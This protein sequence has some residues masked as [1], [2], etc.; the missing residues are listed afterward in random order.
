MLAVQM[1]GHL[2]PHSGA[3]SGVHSTEHSLAVPR[4]AS[5][6]ELSNILNQERQRVHEARH[7]HAVE[8]LQAQ[9]YGRCVERSIPRTLKPSENHCRNELAR[10]CPSSELGQKTLQ[11]GTSFDQ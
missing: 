4:I 11:I 6:S 9:A 3:F 5:I 10:E 2:K 1:I 8:R 7:L